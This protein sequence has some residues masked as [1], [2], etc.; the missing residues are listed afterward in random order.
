MQNYVGQALQNLSGTVEGIGRQGGENRLRTAELGLKRATQALQIPGLKLQA[1]E[2]EAEI[3]QRNQPVN[4]KILMQKDNPE[5]IFHI[6]G[7]QTTK[8]MPPPYQ[9][10]GNIFGAT[11]DEQGNY[12]VDGKPLTNWEFNQKASQV[13]R[14]MGM[15]TDPKK[16]ME[17]RANMAQKSLDSGLDTRTGQPLDE[18][19]KMNLAGGI[20]KVGKMTD[21]DYLRGY[22]QQLADMEASKAPFIDGGGSTALIDAAI[23]RVKGKIASYKAAAVKQEDRDYKARLLKAKNKFEAK[24]KSLDRESKMAI[25]KLKKA[26]KSTATER[27]RVAAIEKE[28]LLGQAIN[29]GWLAEDEMGDITGTLT[30]KQAQQLANAASERGFML[31][32]SAGETITKKYFKD[33][34]ILQWQEFVD[35]VQ[36]PDDIGERKAGQEFKQGVPK[37]N[38]K[39]EYWQELSDGRFQRVYPEEDESPGSQPEDL[40]HEAR[41][42]TEAVEG[43][44]QTAPAKTSSFEND[45]DGNLLGTTEERKEAVAEAVELANILQIGAGNWKALG[46]MAKKTGGAVWNTY[47]KIYNTLWGAEG[48]K[49]AREALYNKSRPKKT[50]VKQLRKEYPDLSDKELQKMAGRL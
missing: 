1:Q 6:L 11:V 22:E 8:N 7:S 41:A 33:D 38:W 32:S 2:N 20:E 49:E 13:Q 37:Q 30:G 29:A 18:K 9:A 40:G 42:G 43:K 23:G 47:L 19:M 35:L 26:G 50:D 45:I 12:I 25:A 5:S 16:A 34:E 46:N 48:R 15:Y 14:V 10:V 36:V 24:Q 27:K 17:T 4:V 44:K 28:Y 21:A 39:G 3:A 31:V